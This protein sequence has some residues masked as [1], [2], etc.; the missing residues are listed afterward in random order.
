[1]SRI[2]KQ[3]ITIPAGVTVKQDG[4]TVTVSGP[5]GTLSTTLHP[6][7]KVSIDGATVNVTRM[8]DEALDRSL[9]G[10]SRTMVANMVEGVTKG[11][12]RK[13]EIH[14]VGYRGQMK[15]AVL[16]LNVGFSHAIDVN[17]PEGIVLAITENVITVSGADKVVVGEVASKIRSYRKPEP[18]KGKGIRY[19][20]EHVR[21]KEGKKAA[22]A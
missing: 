7:A 18:Y 5:K 2:G 15:D 20:G 14:G 21:R 3:P 6:R 11:F 10:T 22:S 16:S 12:E 9:H 8:S 1:M 4:Q 13:L 17:P 19:V